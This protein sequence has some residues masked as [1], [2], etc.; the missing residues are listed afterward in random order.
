[1]VR[2]SKGK[3]SGA[4]YYLC[5]SCS[6]QQLQALKFAA[7]AGFQLLV[8]LPGVRTA[9]YTSQHPLEP[10]V[11]SCKRLSYLVNHQFVIVTVVVAGAGVKVVVMV[12]GHEAVADALETELDALVAEADELGELT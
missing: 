1:M 9:A 7:L 10:K 5:Y 2:S 12:N 3:F 11:T 4:L 8:A 6:L